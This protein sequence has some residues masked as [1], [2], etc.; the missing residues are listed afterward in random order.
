[1]L[2]LD[3]KEISHPHTA[4]PRKKKKEPFFLLFPATFSHISLAR[5]GYTSIPEPIT[6]VREWS[7]ALGHKPCLPKSIIVS[8]TV[9]LY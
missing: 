4:Q 3:S 6:V 2:R 8:K 5:I 1:M 7:Y 9:G